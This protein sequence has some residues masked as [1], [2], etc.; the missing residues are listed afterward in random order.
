MDVY[1]DEEGYSKEEFLIKNDHHIGDGTLFIKK[2]KN[3][4]DENNLY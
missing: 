1:L 4:I 2:L 3:K